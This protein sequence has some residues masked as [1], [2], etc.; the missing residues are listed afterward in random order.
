MNFLSFMLGL[1]GLSFFISGIGFWYYNHQTA[2]SSLRVTATV[3][4]IIEKRKSENSPVLYYP[5]F[6]FYTESRLRQITYHIGF[7]KPPYKAE[8]QV[9]IL[10]SPSQET[11]LISDDKSNQK[12][13]LIFLLIGAGM[14]AIAYLALK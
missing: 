11:A 13:T 4:E 8:D 10:Y 12:L 2:Q 14:L 9:E 6:R 1:M 7:K 3:H 5:V